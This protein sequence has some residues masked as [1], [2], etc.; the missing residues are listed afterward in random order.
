MFRTKDFSYQTEDGVAFITFDMEGESV[1]TLA[2]EVGQQFEQLLTRAR[3]DSD[4]K[5]VVFCSGKKDAF[6]AGAKLDF[7]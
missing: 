5:A 3:S 2:P 7:L 6:I 1:N 4:A